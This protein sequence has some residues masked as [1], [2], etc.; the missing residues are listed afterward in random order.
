MTMT[1]TI[2]TLL[3]LLGLTAAPALAT[4]QETAEDNDG[5]TMQLMERDGDPG[6]VAR[7][8]ELPEGAAD[9]AREATDRAGPA[10]PARERERMREERGDMAESM[11]EMRQEKQQ[12]RE[13]RDEMGQRPD[14]AKPAGDGGFGP[15]KPQ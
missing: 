3:T 8:L 7:S 13:A 10:D 2:L 1:R 6:E 15:G 9:Q 4:A 5:V 12:M 14:A 11:R